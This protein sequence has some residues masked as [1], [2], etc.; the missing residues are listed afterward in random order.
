MNQ[1]RISELLLPHE[2]IP[3]ALFS[4]RELSNARVEASAK[5]LP[6]VLLADTV[7]GSLLFAI[8]LTL[9]SN[10]WSYFWFGALLLISLVRAALASY[11]QDEDPEI[12]PPSHKWRFLA[13]GAV[14]SGIVWGNSLVL[15][16]PDASFAQKSLVIL[17]L[18][19]MFS[20]AT[21]TLAIIKKQFFFFAIPAAT[22]LTLHLVVL[23]TA[24][25]LTLLGGFGLYLAFIIPI[26]WRNSNDLNHGIKL[27]LQNAKMQIKLKAD[28]K[29]LFRK[30]AQLKE[31]RQRG[32]SL[33]TKVLHADEKLQFAAEERLLLLDAVEEGIFGI[34]TQ[35][36]ITFINPSALKLLGYEENE[37]IGKYAIRLIDY[38]NS[39][40]LSQ[41][42]TYLAIT[43]CVDNGEP[44]EGL[45]SVFSQKGGEG[46]PVRFSCR[47][48]MK[49]DEIIGAVVS[50]FDISRQQEMEGILLQSQKMEAMGRLTGGVAHDFNNLLTV[51][52]GNLQFL[53]K[54]ITGDD[55]TTSLLNKIM[56]AARSGAELNNRLLSFAREDDL[57]TSREDLTAILSD[58]HE[59]L[60]RILGEDVT[61]NLTLDD[62]P[63]Y[64]ATDRTRLENAILNICV[65][66]KD[67]MENGGEVSIDIQ[68][69]K[70]DED[71]IVEEGTPNFAKLSI[72]DTGTGIST[73]IQKQIFDPFFTTKVLQKG[74]GLGLSMAYGFIKQS[75]GNI[76]VHSKP[77]EGARFELFLRL[78]DENTIVKESKLDNIP[79][80]KKHEGTILVVEDD[81]HVRDVATKMLEESG[82][83]VVS[84]N[85]G[86]AGLEIFKNHPEI[87][88]VFSDVIMPGGMT[89]LE[90]A[91]KI[92][93]EKPQASILLATG[94]AETDLVAKI[95]KL[96]NIIC[97]PKPYDTNEL[98]NIVQS[99]L[100][101]AA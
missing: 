10:L 95:D 66:A 16:A 94:Y 3:D 83:K 13:I 77:G 32:D 35:G 47:P 7:A 82:Y 17:W 45:S 85:S 64:I 68:T 40:G 100:D 69:L 27:R 99:I 12:F 43:A 54:R 46:L 67:A 65:N 90:L 20:G 14:L 21:S 63:C 36:K 29:R 25:D 28:E 34:N 81:D 19:G 71:F 1:S 55:R 48:I 92:L 51:I 9:S 33:Q 15:L 31:H 58:L 59:F 11:Y 50:F 93:E 60:D 61:L 38:N 2:T 8:F 44:A 49:N 30:E 57:A 87:D 96:E 22:F 5:Q 98:P 91:E 39:D 72:S 73:E 53:Q 56:N 84:A 26:M 88:L 41:T 62:E 42:Q 97:V 18:S 70:L 23:G 4:H 74:T 24:S 37:I 76:A 86:P 52:M 6:I 89:G 78:A 80:A 101:S 75:G 79:A